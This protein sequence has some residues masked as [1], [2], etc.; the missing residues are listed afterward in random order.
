LASDSAA[1]SWQEWMVK[2]AA[3]HFIV[4]RK[5]T[6]RERKGPGFSYPSRMFPQ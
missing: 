5:Q 6:E 1:S 2:E 4:V 3:A